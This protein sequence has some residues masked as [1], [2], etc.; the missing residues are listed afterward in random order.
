M[1]WGGH[2]FGGVDAMGGGCRCTWGRRC[3]CCREREYGSDLL[4]TW[5]SWHS[6]WGKEGKKVII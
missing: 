6:T 4:S 1:G 2:G 3:D 5:S